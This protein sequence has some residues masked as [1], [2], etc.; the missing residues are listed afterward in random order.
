M[1]YEQS[2]LSIIPL[3]NSLQPSGQSVA[4]QSM[5]M[6]VPVLMTK[7]DGFWDHSVFDNNKNYILS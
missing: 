2:N 1:F 7:T 6:E 3:K 5:S 4:L